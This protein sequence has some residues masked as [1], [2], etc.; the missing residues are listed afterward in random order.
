MK[1]FHTLIKLAKVDVEQYQKELNLVLAKVDSLDMARDALDASRQAEHQKANEHP[2]TAPDFGKF[3]MLYAQKIKQIDAA[4]LALQDEVTCAQDKL[5]GGLCNA[6]R[7]QILL[8]TI[9]C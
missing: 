6:K 7:F 4:K 1:H 2:D 3:L 8:I 5:A 9:I